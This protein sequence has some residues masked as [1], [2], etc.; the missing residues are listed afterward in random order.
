MIPINRPATAANLI[1]RA[2]LFVCLLGAETHAGAEIRLDRDFLAGV[3]DKLPPVP[4]EKADRYRGNVHSYRLEAID[5]VARVFLI[6]CEIEGEFHPKVSGPITDR[7]GRS[8]GTPEGWRKFRFDVKA[9]VNIEPGNEAAPR[10]RVSIDE[11]KRRELDGFSGLLARLIG[12][13]FDEIVTQIASGR[14]SK[15]NQRLNAEIGKRVGVFKEYGVFQ[16]IDYSRDAVVLHFDVTRYRREGIAG[17]VFKEVTPGAV[18]LYRWF[19]PRI[20]S[21]YYTIHPAAPDRPNSLDEGPICQVL[22]ENAPGSVPLYD[23]TN[24]R[25]HLYTTDSSGE[26]AGR[27]GYRPLGITCYVYAEPRPGTVPLYRFRDPISRD[28]FYSTHPHAE[29][30]K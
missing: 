17:H 16:R 27:F 28:H 11:V 29:F 10:F 20:G 13:Y 14:A 7:V 30:A 9:R 18:P 1:L 2:A 12:E 23:W 21:H 8:P 5:P 19:H 25:D 22:N 3:I 4:F 15:L 6:V 24:G 26:G